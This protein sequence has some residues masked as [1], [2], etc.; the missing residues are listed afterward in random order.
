MPTSTSGLTEVGTTLKPGDKITASVT[1]SGTRF[2]LQLTDAT[3][4]ANSFTEHQ[5]CATTTAA[6]P[7]T[8]AEW[9][10]ERPSFGIG[11]PPLAKYNAFKIT[12]GT[13]TANGKAGTIGS[14]SPVSS[15]T[16]VD[17]TDA[18][19]LTTVSGLTTGNSFSVSWQNSY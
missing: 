7:A 8:S 15:I 5:T 11:I 18:Y 19:D 13:E 16:M 12:N 14:F 6:C 1:R 10:V 3:T 9:V 17:A 4:K 2:T